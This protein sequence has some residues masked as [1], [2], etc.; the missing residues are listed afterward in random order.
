MGPGTDLER[1]ITPITQ[2]YVEE[3]PEGGNLQLQ[4]EQNEYRNVVTVYP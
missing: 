2:T 3:V 1:G 4:T